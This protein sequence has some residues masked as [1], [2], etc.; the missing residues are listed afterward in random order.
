MLCQGRTQRIRP[1]RIRGEISLYIFSSRHYDRCRKKQKTAASATTEQRWP[2][3]RCFLKTILVSNNPLVLKHRWEKISV[4]YVDDSAA[5][6]LLTVRDLCHC[7][8]RLL[9]HPLSGSVKPNETPYKSILVS[10]T[11][12][13]TDV[14][15]VQLIEE[16]I[17][18]MNRFGPIR[19]KWHE[20]ELHDFQLV[21]ES[22]I[23]DAADA[24]AN[25]LTII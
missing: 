8:H 3:R 12:S 25:D 17:E 24:S 5:A 23:A 14:E 16:A 9:S 22:L 6:V 7:G 11:A 15:S 21:D 1:L 13:G 20:K 10:E 19:R 4:R 18:V 2:K